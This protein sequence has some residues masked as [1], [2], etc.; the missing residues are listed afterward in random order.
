M[1][2]RTMTRWAVAGSLTL[3]AAAT[4]GGCPLDLSFLLPAPTGDSD[5]TNGDAGGDT[6]GDVA[7]SDATDDM[8]ATDKPL[9]E[10]ILTELLGKTEFVSVSET[11]LVCHSGQALDLLDT[12]HWNWS[13]A[14]TNIEGLEGETHGKVDLINNFCIAVPSNEGRCTQ[15][16]I[17]YGWKSNTPDSFFEDRNNVDCF[18]CH[19]TT[20]TYKK[21]PT[22]DGGGG[23]AAMVVDGELTTVAPA[24]LTEVAFNVGEPQRANCLACHAY[25]GGGD[26]VKHGD[27]SSDLADPT[28]EQDV[29]MGG[30]DFSCQQCHTTSGH[31]IAGATAL[32]S[33][34]GDVS[35]EQCHTLTP[36][37]GGT[38]GS[39]LN[40]HTDRIACQTCHIPTFSR[41]QATKMEWY[42]D[43]AGEDRTDIPEQ[44]GKPTYDKK[45]GRFVWD[46]N[47]RP[48]YRWYN[49]KWTRKVVNVSDTYTEAGTEDDPV[50]LAA[51]TATADDPD[52]KLYPFK[53][54]IGRQIADTTEK[55]M[56]VPHL[57]GMGPGPNPFWAKFDWG[58][59]AEEGAAYAG[60]PFSGDWGFVNTVS[61]LSI[62]HEVAP[63]DQALS[64]EDCHGVASFWEEIG[65]EDPLDF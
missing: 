2:L 50:V 28:A 34:E 31:R 27:L 22:A 58:L 30:M 29:H 1:N 23:P 17:G 24:D 56:I 33:A 26:N 47:V 41:T 16:H 5:Q 7:D 45:K 53:R 42:W 52:A 15:C 64:C 61:Y 63:A 3:A 4:L 65:I 12:A 11:C 14:V 35:C 46:M 59:A 51:P 8:G 38:V 62:N 9:H 43:E 36:H 55:R 21:H 49:G 19:D 20:G 13:G 32:H 44:F 37:T 48:A 54:F 10:R 39:V 57:F 40:F 6:G 18:V 25:A 60:Q